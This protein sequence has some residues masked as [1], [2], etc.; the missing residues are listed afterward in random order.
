MIPLAG[1]GTAAKL[2]AVLFYLE[3][4]HSAKGNWH[5]EVLGNI[6]KPVINNANYLV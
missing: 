1:S 2:P 6:G 5:E 3:K 4:T